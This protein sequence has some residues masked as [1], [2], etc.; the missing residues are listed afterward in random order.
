LFSGY[1][2][3]LKIKQNEKISDSRS[4]SA[5]V[6]PDSGTIRSTGE[7]FFIQAITRYISENQ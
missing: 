5:D 1:L 6:V 3:N 4:I 7:Q 2:C